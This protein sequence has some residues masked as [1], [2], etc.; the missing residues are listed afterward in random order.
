MITITVDGKQIEVDAGANL[1]K[2]CL[3]NDIYIPNLCYI[4]DMV[5]PPAAC[6]LCWVAIEGSPLP[7]PACA[8]P[9]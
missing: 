1:L 6:R 9:R 5:E 2:V 8:T 7:T 3:A 4:A